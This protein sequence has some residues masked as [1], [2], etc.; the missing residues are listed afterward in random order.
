MSLI[1]SFN[2]R[3]K[4]NTIKRIDRQQRESPSR[5]GQLVQSLFIV[6]YFHS[7]VNCFLQ[8][9]ISSVYDGLDLLK[10]RQVILWHYR[11]EVSGAEI[12][13][14][15]QRT[16]KPLQLTP[17]AKAGGISILDR[18]G[19]SRRLKSKNVNGD[20]TECK[21]D[22]GWIMGSPRTPPC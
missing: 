14:N 2:H 16:R 13:L 22:C 19:S 7:L 1:Y 5:K 21:N 8:F 11:R 12:R 15:V 4:R 9:N 3:S 20:G 10:P 17:K 18:S 6:L